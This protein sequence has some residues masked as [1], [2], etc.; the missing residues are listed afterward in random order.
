MA[1]PKLRR[2]AL[3]A[4]AV[5]AIWIVGLVILG[6]A[7]SG[8]Y[9]EQVAS[10]IGESLQAESTIEGADLAFV[11]GR[12]QL[13][14]LRVRRDDSVGKLALDVPSVR[15]E[16][17]PLGLLL[18][19]RQCHDLE[20]RGV[21]LEVSTFA[22]FKLNRPKRPP[23]RAQRVVI[24]DAV[25][26]FSPSALV[27]SIG[28]TRITIEHAEAGP[29][30]FKTPLSWLFALRTLRASIDLPGVSVKLTYA[31]GIFTAAGNIFGAK[32]VAFPVT[33]PAADPA[34]DGRAEVAKLVQLGPELAKRL[35]EQKAEDWL[36]SKLSR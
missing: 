13:D 27:P 9:G 12:L 1:S 35:I 29:T 28:Q 20:V 30:V 8:K 36:E 33:L 19:D 6:F 2:I 34:D 4:G 23:I 31:N 32:P 17:A 25:L 3:I 18:V 22:L 5:F 7:L 11:R 24:E 21:R 15:C 10:R 14:G 16:L 26:A